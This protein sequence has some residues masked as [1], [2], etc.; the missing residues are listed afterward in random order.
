M[1]NALIRIFAVI[2]LTMTASAFAATPIKTVVWDD[3]DSQI[4]NGAS[5]PPCRA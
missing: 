5:G 1:L 2:I 4:L 3:L